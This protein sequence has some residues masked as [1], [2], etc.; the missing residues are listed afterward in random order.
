MQYGMGFYCWPVFSSGNIY[1]SGLSVMTLRSFPRR[2]WFRPPEGRE[3]AQKG[4][5]NR[6]HAPKIAPKDKNPTPKNRPCRPSHLNLC[7]LNSLSSR[8]ALFFPRCPPLFS[9]CFL[10]ETS[11][12][13]FRTCC[14]ESAQHSSEMAGKTTELVKNQGGNHRKS[15]KII[16]MRI[17]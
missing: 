13:S 14:A 2:V 16:M 17:K 7:A 9:P 8:R 6:K 3:S 12:V 5:T 4:M 1:K 15:L 11:R 10:Q